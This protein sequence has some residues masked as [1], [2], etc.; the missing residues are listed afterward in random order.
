[1]IGVDITYY[2]EAYSLGE[3]QASCYVKACGPVDAVLKSSEEI[4]R[5]MRSWCARDRTVITF[6]VDGIPVRVAGR[7]E[8]PS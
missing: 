3:V 6:R 1:M 5:Q 7:K 2:V 4:S 8:N